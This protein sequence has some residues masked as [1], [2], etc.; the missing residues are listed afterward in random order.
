MRLK[1]FGFY[2]AKNK[3]VH[4][5]LPKYDAVDPRSLTTDPFY[6]DSDMAANEDH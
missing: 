1:A 5:Y 6:F 4:F 3:N 2:D